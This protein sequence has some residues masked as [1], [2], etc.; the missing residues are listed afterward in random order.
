MNDDK[1]SKGL[2]KSDRRDFLKSSLLALGGIAIVPR[3]VLG[4]GYTAPSDM[5]NLGVIGLGKQGGILSNAFS[6]QK[7]AR[8]VAGADVWSTKRDWFKG[9][10]AEAYAKH[11]VKVKPQDVITYSNYKELLEDKNIDGVIIATPDHW[12]ALNAI[13]AMKAGK[14]VYCEKPLTLKIDEGIKMVDTSRKTKRVVQ[15][16]SMQRSWD[17]FIKGCELVRN[18]YI[19]EVKQVL[20]QVGAPSRPYDL[21]KEPLPAEVDWDQWCGPA[22]ILGYHHTIAPAVNET[23]PDWRL[24]DETGGG[25]L[26]DWGAHMFDIAQWGLGMDRTGPVKFIAPSGVSSPQT[27]LK[28]YYENGVEMIHQD[29]GRGFGLRFIGTEGSL[30]VSRSYMDPSNAALKDIQLKADD[31]RLGNPDGDHYKNFLESMKSRKQ[32]HCD[33]EIGH[34][35]ATIGNIANIA[36]RLNKDLDWDPKKEKFIGDKDANKMMSYKYRKMV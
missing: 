10:V 20:V 23:Y 22:P 16:G 27:G 26:T 17:G 24:F 28:M 33:V 3:H 34:R 5:I 21:P 30:D 18:G 36:Y 35:S 7:G 2:K 15:T 8:I 29:F 6:G 25:I 12:H 32:P 14:D 1:L 11:D 9:F 4:A 19:G 31:I 13:D